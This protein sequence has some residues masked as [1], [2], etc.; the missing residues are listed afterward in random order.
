MFRACCNGAPKVALDTSFGSA[1]YVFTADDVVQE[2]TTKQKEKICSCIL[3][4][5]EANHRN[6]I[7]DL[8]LSAPL[9]L[10]TVRIGR[11]EPR[12]PIPSR[13]SVT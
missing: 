7:K 5:K 10:P 12:G 13:G 4:K 3:E 1:S 2:L 6:S 9:Q 8:R 11:Y